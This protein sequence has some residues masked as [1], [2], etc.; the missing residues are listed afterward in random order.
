M[1]SITTKDHRAS[2]LFNNDVNDTYNRIRTRA[3][4][5]SKENSAS[6]DPAGVE[7]IQLHAVD[8]NTKIT[9]NI[10]SA[11][12][13]D[14]AEI[15]A[16]KIFEAFPADLQKALTSESLDEV[17]KAEVVVE[18]LG[19]GG[20]LSLE[21]GIID[22]TTDEGQKKLAEIEAEGKQEIGEPGGDVAELD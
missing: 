11:D 13:Q 3:A 19:N 9:I 16:R 21:E 22:G 1:N 20:M 15:E 12:S 7:Q 17:N 6:N 5:L 2:T 8:P 18:Q 4:E 14:P 10:P